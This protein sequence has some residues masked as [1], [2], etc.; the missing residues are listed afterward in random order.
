MSEAQKIIF[1]VNGPLTE[2]WIN[3][4]CLDD[5]NK[6][7]DIEYWDCTHLIEHANVVS[8]VQERDYVHSNITWQNLDTNLSRLPKNSII[9]PEIAIAPC[10][11][12]LFWRIS[13][14]VQTAINVDFWHSPVSIGIP[15]Q[16]KKYRVP[17]TETFM[18]KVVKTIRNVSFLLWWKW[19]YT[20]Y[21]FSIDPS[22]KYPL[23]TPDVEK[24]LSLQNVPHQNRGRYVVYVGQFFPFHTDTIRLEKRDLAEFAKPFYDS[25][26]LYFDRIERELKCKV[27]IAEHPSGKHIANPF[28]GREIV[29]YKTAEL[30]RDS[31]AV[32]MH[33]SNS[34]SFVVLYDKPVAILSCSAIEQVPTFY[35]HLRAFADAV[36]LPP[37]NIEENIPVTS[38]FKK[39]KPNVRK[40]ILNLLLPKDYS[41]KNNELWEEYI[42]AINNRREIYK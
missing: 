22:S 32:C 36:A 21:S 2:R 25:L 37:I 17:G 12:R 24:Y 42:T 28:N 11:Y 5:L 34:S 29:Y 1:L 35:T 14:Y 30:I 31:I 6:K 33:F 39:L 15:D 4:F 10:N 26:N 13:K 7:F 16:A 8:D 3:Y 27:I 40:R 9:V 38:T 19:R 41:K 20:T 23:N 18:Q